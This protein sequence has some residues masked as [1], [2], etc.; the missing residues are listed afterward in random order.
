MRRLCCAMS[1]A[2]SLSEPARDREL[3]F[4]LSAR[5]V[6]KAHRPS[7]QRGMEAPHLQQTLG[8]AGQL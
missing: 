3:L 8:L 1:G 4:I 5:E 2:P 6:S 7:L